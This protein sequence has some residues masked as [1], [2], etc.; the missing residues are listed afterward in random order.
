MALSSI[1]IYSFDVWS[2]VILLESSERENMERRLNIATLNTTQIQQRKFAIRTHLLGSHVEFSGYGEISPWH[3]YTKPSC[4][5]TQPWILLLPG[6]K[7]DSRSILGDCHTA[8]NGKSW[9]PT[10]D[11]RNILWDNSR[12]SPCHTG[13]PRVGRTNITK[14]SK[15]TTGSIGI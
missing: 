8:M 7:L 3:F 6:S 4:S 5:M 15:V 9:W 10:E 1:Q 11:V 14:A 2:F 13:G 12:I